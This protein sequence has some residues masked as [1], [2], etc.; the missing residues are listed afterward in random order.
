MGPMGKYN[1]VSLL[2]EHSN[3]MT[4][5]EIFLATIAQCLAQPQSEKLLLAADG[6]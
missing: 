6:N 4:S 2:N 1:T 3:K 5:N